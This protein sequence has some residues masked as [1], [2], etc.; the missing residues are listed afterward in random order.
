MGKVINISEYLKKKKEKESECF[1]ITSSHFTREL[2]KQA[3]ASQEET[4]EYYKNLIS[5][6]RSKLP[7][8][9]CNSVDEKEELFQQGFLEGAV[10]V[11]L[12]AA[13]TIDNMK[14]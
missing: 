5:K 12:L 14:Y 6:I 3:I 13:S 2:H 8:I 1:D 10:F 9:E 7:E 11:D 4:I